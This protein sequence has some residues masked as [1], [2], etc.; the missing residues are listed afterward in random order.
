[1][2]PARLTIFLTAALSAVAAAAETDP[3]WLA[4]ARRA[5]NEDVPLAAIQKLRAALDS[6]EATGAARAEAVTLLAEAQLNSGRAA[7]ALETLAEMNGDDAPS[8]VRVRAIALLDLGRRE[9]ALEKFRRLRALGDEITGRAGEAEAL[10]A[11]DRTREAA[12]MLEPFVNEDSPAPLR[13]QL[14]SLLLELDRPD[15]A[16]ELIDSTTVATATDAHWRRYIEARLLLR[17]G[18]PREALATL[19]SL[20]TTPLNELSAGLTRNL[21]AAAVIAEAEARLAT[22]GPETA[23]KTLEA[24]IRQNPGSPHLETVFH[25]LDHLYAQDRSADE[26]PLSRMASDLPPR[27][28]ALAQYYLARVHIRAKRHE[29]AG[30]ALATF[31][32]RHP[33]HPLTPY[34]HAALAETQQARGELA[35][36]EMSLDA[37]SRTA[38][39]DTLRG[40]LALQ[41]ALLNLQ[42]GEFVRA[43]TGFRT[44]AQ[45]VPALKVSAQY[46]SA[47]AWLRQKNFERFEEDYAAFTTEFPDTTLAGN[48]RLEAGLVRA[49]SGDAAARPALHAYLVQFTAHPRRAEAHLAIAELDLADGNPPPPGKLEQEIAA[50]SPA[51][52]TKEQSEYLGIFLEDARKPRDDDRTIARARDFIHAH[53]ESPMLAEVRMKLGEIHFRREDYLKAQEQFETLARER[54]DSPHATPA[55]FLAGQCSMKLLNAEALSR[56]LE[57]FGAVVEKH[58]PLELHARLHQAAIKNQLGAPDDAVKLYDTILAAQPPPEPAL[59]LAALMGRADNLVALGRTEPK[60][61]DAAIAAY[62]QLAAIEGVAPEWRNQAAYKKAKVIQQRDGDDRAFAMLYD[63]L[64]KTITGPRET[65]WF[66]KAGFDAAA[67]AESRKDWKSAAG[68]Y[69]KMTALQGPHADQARQRLRKLRLEHFLWD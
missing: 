45:R 19:E 34:A 37:A 46:D 35:A 33:E 66:A 48:L 4:S 32:S 67:L 12:A 30:T 20:V 8:V 27:A 55:L 56:A 53:P 64:D 6:G 36:A 69:E 60:Q 47:L 51:P 18:K 26:G 39:S 14:A 63:I 17:D 52:E 24:F 59:R 5:L 13:L 23:E 41:T 11:L 29:A 61:L 28:A 2:N 3:A 38:Q 21:H 44:A 65:F 25:R 40:E 22:S 31:L 62:E 49:R 16:H 15:D 57:L 54:P 42:Q 7:E 1:M 68:V 9:E 43:S 10:R 58:G 50:A